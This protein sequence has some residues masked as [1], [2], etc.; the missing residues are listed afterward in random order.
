MSVGRKTVLGVIAVLVIL[1]AG[2]YGQLLV[3]QQSF[4]AGA[5]LSEKW[6]AH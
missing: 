2:A 6:T 1:T 3:F 5:M 4:S